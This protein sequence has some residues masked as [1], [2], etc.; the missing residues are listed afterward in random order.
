MR[1]MILFGLA[2]SMAVALAS[3]SSLAGNTPAPKNAYVYLGW[4]NDGEHVRTCRFRVWFGL[5][6]MGIAPASVNKK[7]TG[8]HHLIIDAP[9]PPFDREIPND[10]NHIHFGAGQSEAV[11]ELAPGKHTLQLLF[12]DHNHIPHN[13]PIYSRKRTI[14]VTCSHRR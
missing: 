14:T 9:L 11:I 7:N 1:K 12:A 4:P 2:A 5:R 3:Q 13:P 6:H 8:H 10:R